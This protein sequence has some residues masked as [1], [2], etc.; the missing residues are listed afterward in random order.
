MRMNET[1][2]GAR[3][4]RRCA[5]QGV[6]PIPFGISKFDFDSNSECM[7]TSASY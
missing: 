2:R 5:H 1:S 4:A 3:E 6:D 7:T